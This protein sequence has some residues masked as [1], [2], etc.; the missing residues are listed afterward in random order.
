MEK[1]LSPTYHKP[2]ADRRKPPSA[3]LVGIGGSGMRSLAEVLL[4]DG[5]K[6]SGSD[7][8][9]LPVTSLANAGVSIHHGHH[10][11]NLPAD[12]ELVVHSDAIAADNPELRRAA[13]LGVPTRSYFEMLGRLMRGRHGLAVAGTHGKSTTTAMAAELLSESGLDP[14][15]ICGA[16]PL[17]NG[18]RVPLPA[19]PA[20]PHQEGERIMLV[21]ACEYRANFLHLRPRHAVILGIEPDHFDFYRS[22]E[23]LE[24]AFSRFARSIPHDGLLLARHDCPVTRRIS[25]GSACGVETFGIGPGADWTADEL[26]PRLG[27]YDFRLSRRGRPLGEVTLRVPGRHNVLNAVAAAALASHNGVSPEVI[28]RALG[29]FRGLRR[30]L[31]WRGLWRGVRLVDDYAHHPT[32]VAAA[33]STVRSM[34]PGRPLWC[35]FQPHQTSRTACLLDELAESM[36]NVDRLL[37]AEIFRAREPSP[38]PGEVTAADLARRAEM[39]GAS[40]HHIHEKNEIVRLLETRLESGDVLLTMGAG[41]I[42]SICDRLLAT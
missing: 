21:E 36:Q 6:L 10:A 23:E 31:Q 16:R 41:D 3:H 8:V 18:H 35:V 38:R 19:R 1:H 25:A 26:S 30:R 20:V 9:E 40:V 2:P 39:A 24:D 15:V 28:P 13:E 22:P 29:Q 32:E 11:E 42:G 17:E 27:R 34:F 4:A 5:W 14:T 7:L 12:T 33:L 37:V